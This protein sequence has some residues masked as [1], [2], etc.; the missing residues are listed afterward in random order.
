MRSSPKTPFILIFALSIFASITS[1][2]YGIVLP[3]EPAPVTDKNL[4]GN[5]AKEAG[6]IPEAWPANAEIERLSDIGKHKAVI[7]ALTLLS[8]AIVS[9]M[10]SLGSFI[11]RMRAGSRPE[12][13]CGSQLLAS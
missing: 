11:F 4:T 10:R 2:A 3:Q 12:P 6:A 8:L 13:D 5:P 7:S 1:A 9:F